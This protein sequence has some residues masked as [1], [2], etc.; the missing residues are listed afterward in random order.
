[1]V[2][3]PTPYADV[4]AILAQLLGEAQNVLGAQF[5]GMYL[6]GSLASGD[7]DPASSDIDFAVVTATGLPAETVSALELMHTRL[8]AGGSDWAHKLEGAY[9]PADLIRRHDPHG[10]ACPSLNE[11][12]FVVDER[13]SDWIIQRHVIRECG[14]I[15]KGPDPKTLIEPVSPTEIRQAVL[16]TLYEWWFPMLDDPAWLAKNGAPY[17]AFAVITMCRVLHALAHGTIVSKPVAAAW[18]Q[19]RFDGRWR[20]LIAQAL[21]VRAVGRTQHAPASVPGFLDGSLDLIR[22]VKAHIE[23]S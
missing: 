18:A 13:G 21:E 12:R 2:S 20:A 15:V 19:D 3:A 9:L 11:G 6:Y 16:G 5:V 4:N 10:A 1:M 8:A 22:F 14:L 7:F 17:Q 23:N